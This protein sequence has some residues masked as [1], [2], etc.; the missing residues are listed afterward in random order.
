MDNPEEQTDFLTLMTLHAAK[1]LEFPA[2]FIAGLEEGLLPHQRVL[3]RKEELEEERRLCYV[4]ITRAQERL[5]LCA[6]NRRLQHGSYEPS[7]PSRFLEELPAENIEK[8][9]FTPPPRPVATQRASKLTDN[10]FAP[11]PKP[12]P[13]APPTAN[14]LIKLGDKVRHTKFGDG[15]VVTVSGDGEDMQLTVAFPGQGIK[16]LMWRYAPLKKI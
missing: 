13:P 1:G 6:A 15:V 10:V 14:R 5:F 12:L 16:Q 9:G 2:V 11:R 4:G 8:S 7:L 3:F